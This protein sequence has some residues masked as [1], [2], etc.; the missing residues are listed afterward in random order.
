MRL[1]RSSCNWKMSRSAT[2]EVFDQ[3]SAPEGVSI[4]CVLTR[5]WPP[6]V[7]SVPVSTT[8]TSA[9]SAIVFRFGASP[10]KRA[11]AKL[12]RTINDSRPANEL[13]MASGRLKARKSV[14]GSGRRMRNGSTIKRLITRAHVVRLSSVREVTEVAH[15]LLTAGWTEMF[16]S[17]QSE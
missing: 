17:P 10:A 2:C 14:S 8:S 7:S 16:G 11:A 3:M 9:S 6:E 15:A 12:E 4:S 5:N 13:V 1:T